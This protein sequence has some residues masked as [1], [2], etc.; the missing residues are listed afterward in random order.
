MNGKSGGSS[1]K[2]GKPM[3]RTFKRDEEAIRNLTPDQYRVTQ[4]CAT[5]APG[6][7]EYLHGPRFASVWGLH[8]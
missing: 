3:P 2:I 6:A 8:S 7:G 4:Q 1:T 5:E